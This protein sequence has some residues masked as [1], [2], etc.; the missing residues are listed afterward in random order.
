VKGDD[1]HTYIW[2]F[3][4]RLR[5]DGIVAN[6]P[7]I[8]TCSSCGADYDFRDRRSVGPFHFRIVSAHP[9]DGDD[10]LLVGHWRSGVWNQGERLTLRMRD[11]GRIAVGTGPLEQP[12]TGTAAYER[13]QIQVK[14]SA[15]IDSATLEKGCLWS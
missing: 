13:G 15:A 11:G 9:G 2:L 5:K 8:R 12:S 10:R 6:E 7:E 1:D 14:I 3:G 4:G